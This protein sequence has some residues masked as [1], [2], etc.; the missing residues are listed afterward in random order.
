MLT[1]NS[2]NIVNA[3]ATADF[4]GDGK[5]DLVL[6]TGPDSNGAGSALFGEL[7]IYLSNGD[8]TF[9][10]PI[11]RT[12][13]TNA[14]AVATGDFNSDGNMDIA[15][16]ADDIVD[17]GGYVAVLLGN[18]KGKFGSPLKFRIPKNH[19]TLGL[20]SPSTIAAGD[21][22]GDKNLDIAVGI[23]NYSD[24]TSYVLILLGNG[25]GSFHK[26]QLVPAG[27]NPLALAVADLN[28]DG[29]P[30]LAVANPKCP[31][32][33]ANSCIAVLTGNGNGTFQRPQFFSLDSQGATT[34]TVAD[35]NG[36]GK[37]DVAAP[38]SVT[39]TI[40][41]LLNTTPSPKNKR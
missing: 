38:N 17:Y 27:W 25:D 40:S 36:D 16:L 23:S 29:I 21:F 3:F 24:Q 12:T 2:A 34:L 26:G 6:V 39:R 15:V 11:V 4:N 10:P 33:S 5:D 7:Y 31:D 19:G 35:F 28:G 41:V 13:V 37:P 32:G 22:D 9:Q 1:V 14:V 18:G 30:D 20:S 8:G